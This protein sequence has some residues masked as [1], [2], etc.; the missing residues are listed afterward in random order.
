MYATNLERGDVV[1]LLDR[2]AFSGSIG[3]PHCVSNA[4]TIYGPT[5]SAAMHV[6]EGNARY[7]LMT[8]KLFF[9]SLFLLIA[10]FRVGILGFKLGLQPLLFFDIL[11]SKHFS[12]FAAYPRAIGLCEHEK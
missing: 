2:L 6:A 9:S 5:A 10:C 7:V 3:Y 1:S 8:P 11:Q 4:L 12:D